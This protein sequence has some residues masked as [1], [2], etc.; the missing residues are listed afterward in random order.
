[1]LRINRRWHGLF[2]CTFNRFRI[3]GPPPLPGHAD[4]QEIARH[5]ACHPKNRY[6]L[7]RRDKIISRSVVPFSPSA[8]LSLFPLVDDIAPILRQLFLVDYSERRTSTCA[9]GEILRIDTIELSYRK[10]FFQP[11]CRGEKENAP[12]VQHLSDINLG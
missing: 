1:M 8:P 7:R 10:S 11:R 4:W 9:L 12:L 3:K 5:P 2:I 6:E